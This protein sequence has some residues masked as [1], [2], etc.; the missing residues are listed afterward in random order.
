MAM[1]YNDDGILIQSLERPRELPLNFVHWIVLILQSLTDDLDTFCIIGIIGILNFYNF[2]SVP[3]NA[4]QM[5][6]AGV[7]ETGSSKSLRYRCSDSLF[8]LFSGLLT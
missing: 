6:R 5:L 8:Q 7:V 3:T 4:E 2:P 1:H